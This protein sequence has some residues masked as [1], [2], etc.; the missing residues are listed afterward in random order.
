MVKVAV[1]GIDGGSWNILKKMI[2]SGVMP[3][4]K[5][6]ANLGAWG[7]LKSL[8]P[9]VTGGVW[10]S[11]ATGLN[12]GRTGVIDFFKRVDGYRLAPVSSADFEG[13]S[14]WDYA[15]Y[16]GLRVG[17]LNYPMLHPPYPVNGFMVSGLG[18]PDPT[19]STWPP[20][21]RDELASR[22]A[23]YEVYVNYHL[24]KYDDLDLFFSDVEQHMKGYLDALR[25]LASPRLDLFVTVVQASD[26]VFHRL[27]AYIDEGHPL[28][29]K[30]P[31]SE[32]SRVRRWFGEFWSMVDEAV[33]VVLDRYSGDGNVIVVSDHGFGPQHGVFNLVR[34]LVNRGFMKLKEGVVTKYSLIAR[35]LLLTI[36]SRLV[37]PLR[38]PIKDKVARI[39]TRVLKRRIEDI[40]DFDNSIAV[41]LSHSIPFGAV[42]VLRKEYIN[43]VVEELLRTFA[44]LGLRASVWRPGELYSGD[45]IGLLP[46]IIFLVEDG[47]V[48]VLQGAEH[49]GRPLYT[50]EPYSFRHT[51]SHRIDGIFAAYGSNIARREDPVNASVLDI[52]P[53]V[54]YLLGLPIPSNMDGRVV[55]EALIGMGEP[56]FVGPEYYAR[57]RAVFKA[58]VALSAKTGGMM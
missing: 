31:R 51:G 3:N 39:G 45:R 42:Y 10:L 4:L 13:R 27:W 22:G 1:L 54:M 41:V 57:L 30:L 26:W 38:G 2:D 12:P 5:H 16:S 14:V 48:V 35:S 6:I 34:W 46:D 15:S 7:V 23:L 24:I 50:D 55:T 18:S 40:V 33:G 36:G 28:H 29:S 17:V 9:P 37:K 53:T 56:R 58:R 20:S 52:A 25:I 11:I 49:L 47:R 32:V 8:I 21:L 43:K 19:P 44:E